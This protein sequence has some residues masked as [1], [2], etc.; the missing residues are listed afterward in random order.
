MSEGFKSVRTST[1][2]LQEAANTHDHLL[3]H[4]QHIRQIATNTEY[5]LST[6]QPYDKMQYIPRVV[7]HRYIA[8]FRPAVLVAL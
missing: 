2:M 3:K 1:H 8:P 5:T 4:Q 7:L 6:H